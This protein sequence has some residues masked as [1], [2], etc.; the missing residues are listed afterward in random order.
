MS[1]CTSMPA[2][3]WRIPSSNGP[4]PSA[5]GAWVETEMLR[6]DEIQQ[7]SFRI[8]EQEI[9]THDLGAEAWLVVRRVIHSTGDFEYARLLQFH[10]EAFAAAAAAIQSGADIV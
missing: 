3:R 7:E 8:I 6:P 2:H 9:G 5:V 10:P 1:I 4:S